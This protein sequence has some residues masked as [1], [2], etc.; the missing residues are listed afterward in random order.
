M[1]IKLTITTTRPS[2]DINFFQPP[3]LENQT[4]NDRY[5]DKR[6]SAFKYVSEDGLVQTLSQIWKDEDSLHEFYMDPAML[7]QRTATVDYNLAN[8]II[9][10][11]EGQEIINFVYAD[12]STQKIILI[13]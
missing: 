7:A 4:L 9:S 8:G 13:S 1:P 10:N 5:I 2:T 11:V 6:L 3:V 12:T